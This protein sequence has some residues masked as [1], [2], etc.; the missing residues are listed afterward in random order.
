LLQIEIAPRLLLRPTAKLLSYLL[1]PTA[2]TVILFTA[3]H[4]PTTYSTP[5]PTACFA[6]LWISEWI[7]KMAGQSIFKLGNNLDLTAFTFCLCVVVLITTVFEGI[8]HRL[9]HWIRHKASDITSEVY[10]QTL[11]KLYKELMIL[12]FI[13]FLLSILLQTKTVTDKTVIVSF[14]YG[15]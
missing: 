8:L 4:Q 1:R 2:I 9:E 3:P 7:V 11:Q 6:L 5:G 12:G 15:K 13:S 10:M 14:E